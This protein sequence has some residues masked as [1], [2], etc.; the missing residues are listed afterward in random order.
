MANELFERYTRHVIELVN[1]SNLV[2]LAVI[3]E[4]GLENANVRFERSS[5]LIECKHR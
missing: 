5:S 4:S 1:Y 2:S 3:K